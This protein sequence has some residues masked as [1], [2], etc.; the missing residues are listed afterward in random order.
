VEKEL[1]PRIGTFSQTGTLGNLID[2][3]L[4]ALLGLFQGLPRGIFN[5]LLEVMLGQPKLYG[6]TRTRQRFRCLEGGNRLSRSLTALAVFAIAG[7]IGIAINLQ[8]VGEIVVVPGSIVPGRRPAR[9]RTDF[10]RPERSG[11]T[12]RREPGCVRPYPCVDGAAINR[13]A[14][15]RPT[16][17]QALV[18]RQASL[19]A[20]GRRP[21]HPRLSIGGSKD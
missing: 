4:P 7:K 8:T 17:R 20:E 13:R 11:P 2:R 10:R 21:F 5:V 16:Y 12:G 1:S 9:R 15:L 14:I 18:R 3:P 19:C 6:L